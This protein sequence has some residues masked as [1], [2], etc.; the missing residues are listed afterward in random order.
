MLSQPGLKDFL[1][2]DTDCWP[3]FCVGSPQAWSS[4]A[5]KKAAPAGNDRELPDSKRAPLPV[6]EMASSSVLLP[7]ESQKPV[8]VSGFD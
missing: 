6:G 3:R 2:K 4:A 7:S 8:S 5:G 1:R